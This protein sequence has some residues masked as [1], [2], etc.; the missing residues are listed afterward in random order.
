MFDGEPMLTRFV[1]AIYEQDSSKVRA[2]SQHLDINAVSASGNYTP[3]KLAV[4]RAVE[5]EVKPE[6]ADRALE[7]VRLL[8]SLGAKPKSG[9]HAACFHSSRTDAVRMLLEGEGVRSQNKQGCR[10]S[11]T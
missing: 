7:M 3:L 11:P 2:L 6:A 8:L 10:G 1:V 4:E 5:A 9:L